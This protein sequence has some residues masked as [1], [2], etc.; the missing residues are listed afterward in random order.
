MIEEMTWLTAT[1]LAEAPAAEKEE[2]L[3]E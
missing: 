1:P 3:E 2:D